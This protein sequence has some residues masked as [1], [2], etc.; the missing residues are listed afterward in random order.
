MSELAFREARGLVAWLSREEGLRVLLGRNPLPGENVQ[1]PEESLAAAQRA[2]G[3]RPI[4]SIESPVLSDLPPVVAEVA[5]RTDVRAAFASVSWRV[6]MVDLRHVLSFQKVVVTEG[7]DERIPADV[8]TSIEKLVELCLPTTHAQVPS[9]AFTDADGHG[10]TLS[11]LNPNLRVAGGQ[12][13]SA[14]VSPS[15]DQPTQ[16][17]TAITL[18]VFMG[19]SYLQVAS[20]GGR[21]FVRDGNHRVAGLI[22]RGVF[23]VPCILIEAKTFEELVGNPAG[24]FTYEVLF[25]D[26]PPFVADFWDDGVS[27]LARQAAVRKVVRVRAE[28]FVVP[29]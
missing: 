7:L 13:S 17:M 29:R 27:R 5:G 1:G 16:K 21:Y 20:Y 14:E 25:S 3:E 24:V 2:L 26:R 18:L 6:A 15:P 23:H 4:A 28:E 11:S 22:R 19:A 8:G 10:F 9:E 12:V